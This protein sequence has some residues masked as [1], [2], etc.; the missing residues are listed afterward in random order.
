MILEPIPEKPIVLPDILYALDK[1]DLQPQYQDSLRQLVKLLL[2]NET[3]VIELRSH[4]D[5]RGSDEY[6]EE[7]SQK[8]AQSVVDFLVSQGVDPGRLVAKGYG[9]RIPRVL[10]KDMIRDNYLFKAGTEMNDRF[11]NSLPSDEIKEA[12]FQLNRRTEFSVLS[13]D[14]KR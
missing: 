13:K 12:A 2:V 6:N 10:D 1:W 5:S 11:I 8:R 4:T 7:L 9:E 14:Y 3:L